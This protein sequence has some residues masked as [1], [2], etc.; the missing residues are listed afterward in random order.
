MMIKKLIFGSFA[1]VGLASVAF[2]AAAR[3]GVDL[4][5]NFAPPVAYHEVI[6][7]PRAGWLWV[8]GYW[9]WR[10]NH[11]HWVPGH[12]VRARPGYVYHGGHWYPA[13]GGYR[14]ADRDGVPNRYDRFPHNPY[15]R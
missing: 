2:P 14:D 1:A 10:A 12:Y 5:L 13:H 7:A 3:T 9:E 8:P 4:H 15:R 11:Y 6:P